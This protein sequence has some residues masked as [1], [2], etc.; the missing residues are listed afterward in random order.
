M[1]RYSFLVRLF[2]P[3]LHAGL[4]RRTNIAITLTTGV[5]SVIAFHEKAGRS[6]VV[7]FVGF[8]LPSGVGKRRQAGTS[9][10]TFSRRFFGA[11]RGLEGPVSPHASCPAAR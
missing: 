10:P 3:L 6:Q 7:A 11:L 1:V 9:S 4:S 8:L 2:H 5:L